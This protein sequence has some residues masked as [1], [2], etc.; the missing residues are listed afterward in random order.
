MAGVVPHGS[1]SH[2]R[3]RCK[4]RFAAIPELGLRPQTAGIAA[5]TRTNSGMRSG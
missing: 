3:Y 5:A 4:A 2:S 1:D